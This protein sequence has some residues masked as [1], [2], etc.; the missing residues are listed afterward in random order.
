MYVLSGTI[1]RNEKENKTPV[2]EMASSFKE[3]DDR[4]SGE[5]CFQS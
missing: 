5:M 4:Y 2:C 1:A 3:A